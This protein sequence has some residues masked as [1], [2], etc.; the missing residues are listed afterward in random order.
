MPLKYFFTGR[1]TAPAITSRMFPRGHRGCV[2]T[3]KVFLVPAFAWLRRAV[4]PSYQT[5]VQKRIHVAVRE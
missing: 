1:V 2:K 3:Q 5:T 4:Q